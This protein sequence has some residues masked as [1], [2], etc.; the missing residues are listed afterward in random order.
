[1]QTRP[2]PPP[3]PPPRQESLDMFEE[4]FCQPY[5][6]QVKVPWFFF[7]YST[8]LFLE[9]SRLELKKILKRFGIGSPLLPLF[10]QV[11]VNLV[12]T[13]FLWIKN[14]HWNHVWWWSY[15]PESIFR[16][17]TM[18]VGD[19]LN[20]YLRWKPSLVVILRDHQILPTPDLPLQVSWIFLVLVSLPLFSLEMFKLKLKKV[21]QKVW[22]LL[23]PLP[24][25]KLKLK[26]KMFVKKFLKSSG[27]RLDSPTPP[28]APLRQCPKLSCFFLPVPVGFSW[29]LHHRGTLVSEILPPEILH[30]IPC[31]C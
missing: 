10:K 21:S 19:H 25:E 9:M 28:P 12:Y 8:P 30:K 13:I 15:F 29:E 4:L 5:F 31:F 26:L 20:P 17:K 14:Y 22:N 27:F 16:V 23:P 7:G 3:P 6:N 11:K 1:M 2:S 18:S 24:W